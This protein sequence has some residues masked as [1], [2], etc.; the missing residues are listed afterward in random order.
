MNT[1]GVPSGNW[2][3]RF[4]ARWLDHHDSREWYA[5]LT[6]LSGRWP[7]TKRPKKDEEEADVALAQRKRAQQKQSES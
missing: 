7:E 6:R 3:W 2:R 1:P 4:E 5:N